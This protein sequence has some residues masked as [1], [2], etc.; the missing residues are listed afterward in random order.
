MLSQEPREFSLLNKDLQRFAIIGSLEFD[1]PMIRTALFFNA[2]HAG[3][4]EI[5][6]GSNEARWDYGWYNGMDEL[7]H[8]IPPVRSV[9]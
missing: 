4:H 6:I 1:K 9:Y 8:L 7:A 3:R 5:I 2:G